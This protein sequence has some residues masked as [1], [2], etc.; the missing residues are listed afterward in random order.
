MELQR[1]IYMYC[2]K[3]LVN[4]KLLAENFCFLSL[5]TNEATILTYITQTSQIDSSNFSVALHQV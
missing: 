3:L 5:L 1:C 4:L 2:L